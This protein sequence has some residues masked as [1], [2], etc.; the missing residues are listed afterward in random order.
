[1]AIDDVGTNLPAAPQQYID[2]GYGQGGGYPM[3]YDPWMGKPTSNMNERIVMEILAT[4]LP[5]DRELMKDFLS[6]YEAEVE[7]LIRTPNLDM[8]TVREIRRDTEDLVDRA[9][10]QGRKRII[11]S[12]MLKHYKW[13]A[14]L[15]ACGDK[16]LQGLTSIGAIITSKQIS[17]Q[18]VKMPQEQPRV[19]WLSSLNPFRRK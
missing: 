12:K 16:P 14:S 15:S 7:R 13:V 19:G 2:D 10:S 9:M 4:G 18:S 8:A 11:Q 6:M 1:M 5:T 3:G 17:E